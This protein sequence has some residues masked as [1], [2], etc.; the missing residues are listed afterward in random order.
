MRRRPRQHEDDRLPPA[1]PRQHH[2]RGDAGDQPD[3]AVGDEVHAVRHRRS[4]DAEVEV[5][6]HR[7]L[8]GEVGALEVGDARGVERRRHQAVVERRR[9]AVAEVVA[10]RLVQRPDDLAG[11]EH[12]GHRDQR[13]ASA[14]RPSVTAAISHP[15]RRRW[16]PATRRAAT[17]PTHHSVACPGAARR[18]AP[19]SAHSWRAR[20][21]AITTAAPG[22]GRRIRRPSPPRRRR[23]PVRRAR[24]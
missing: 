7:Q 15:T 2:R 3:E 4:G 22:L 10:E 13:R 14:P 11:D 6:G 20:R 19:N 18:I 24:R 1:V 16:R 9:G 5:A 8:V 12:D 17:R 21:R 23:R